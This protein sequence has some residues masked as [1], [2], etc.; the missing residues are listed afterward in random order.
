MKQNRKHVV[1]APRLVAVSIATA[2]GLSAPPVIFAQ[3]AAAAGDDASLQEVTVTG[4]RIARRD[5]TATS[6]IVTVDA[7]T[8][9][10]TSSVGIEASLNQLP[11]FQPGATQFNAATNVQSNA[12]GGVGAAT[13]NLRGL[14]TNRTLVLLDGRRAQ[15]ADATLVVDVN[16]I[17]S[18]AIQNVEII[19]GGASA[20]YGADALAGVVN[21][22]LKKDFQGFAADLQSGISEQGDGTETHV[23]ALIGTRFAEGQGHIMFGVDYSKRGAVEQMNRDFYYNGVRDPGT[24]GG[25]L[26]LASWRPASPTDQASR[27]ALDAVYANFPAG[28]ATRTANNYF[29][30]DG[31]LFQN[32][33]VVNGNYKGNDPFLI[34]RSN[35]VLSGAENPSYLSSPLERYSAFGRAN[36]S[37]SE[38]FGAYIQANFSSTQVSSRST[39]APAVTFWG[40]TIP[41]DFVNYPVP[42]ALQALLQSRTNATAPWALDQT[43]NRIPGIGPEHST[44]T[45]NVYQVLAGLNGVIPGIDWTWDAYASQGR[46]TTL[47]SLD[48][49]F[50]SLQN[51]KNIISAPHYGRN[52]V[53]NTGSGFG[54]GITCTSGL[55]PFAILNGATVSQD[56]LNAISVTMKNHTNFEQQ[57]YEGN[58]Q[59]KLFD[60]PAGE[61]RGALGA[62]YRKNSVVF[63]P[64]RL[65]SSNDVAEQQIGLYAVSATQGSTNVKELYGELLVPLL[66]ELPLV[67]ALELE[68]GERY[69]KYNTAGSENTWKA[70]ANWTLNDY[71]SFRG[72]QQHAAR[73]PNTAELFSGNTLNVVGFAP[74]D[75][76]ASNTQA[77][78]GNVA[79]NPN[80]AKVQALCSAI[81]GTGNSTYDQSP[82]TYVGGAGFFPYEIE[83]LTG[84]TKL[85]TEIAR[86]TTLG[87]VLRSPFDNA[88]LSRATLSID[89]YKIKIEGL[90]G[91]L[92]PV[93]T[94]SKCLNADGAS[95]PSFSINDPGGYCHYIN[96]DPITGDRHL[97]LAPYINLGGLNTSGVDLQFNWASNLSDLGLASLPGS[98][99]FNYLVNYISSYKTQT[100]PSAPFLEYVGTLGANLATATGQYR[101]RSLATFGYNQGSWDVRLGWRHLPSAKDASTVT[102]PLSTV[103]PVKS[104][105]NLNLSANWDI[106]KS[107]SVRAG[108]DNLFDKQP[109]VVGAN[110][111]A[112]NAASSTVP[113]YY[114]VLGRRYFMGIKL[115]L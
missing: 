92:D 112:T 49:G 40:A 78:W 55:D 106:S 5:Y 87:T 33:P 91:P 69:S 63:S 72:G 95:N 51:Y 70:L 102:N 1:H 73:A 6:P 37:F 50:V 9:E 22:I 71:V 67:K 97:V 42:P 28:A 115:N 103:D 53:D 43:T 19:T 56:C 41:A 86:T 46:T 84:S 100:D 101:W 12:F 34:V 29:N 104:Y 111:P 94:Y 62:S 74:A 113:N 23:N 82:G 11:Q 26:Y 25:A 77:P 36:Y 45:S 107:L 39:Y 24:P 58:T 57:V 89:W 54:Y 98:V 88:A 65:L 60:L 2:L 31:T 10:R 3:Q 64:D 20:V 109:V 90:I 66:K 105:D 15:P 99:S 21:F 7:E 30:A 76:C 17:P 38:H 44:T 80:R 79:S 81:I 47:T 16:S 68:L 59:G 85:K 75:P 110:P 108:V 48:N 35:G 8:F 32:T 61:L 83:T 13:V 27:G 14:G 96:R 93:T 52:Y 18:A 4:S 114:D